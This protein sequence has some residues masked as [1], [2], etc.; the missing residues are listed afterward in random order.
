M[1][2]TSERVDAFLKKRQAR[3]TLPTITMAI[4][5]GSFLM[6][7]FSGSL[8]NPDGSLGRGG[9]GNLGFVI[10]LAIF[11]VWRKSVLNKQL[12]DIQKTL[13]PADKEALLR[14]IVG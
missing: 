5:A 1:S 2:E 4:W 13:T 10:V 6:A 11:Y 7:L 12:A 3:N 8:F 9:I 14:E